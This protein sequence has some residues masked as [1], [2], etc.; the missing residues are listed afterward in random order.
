MPVAAAGAAIAAVLV[1]IFGAL[2]HG[3]LTRVPENTLK[4]GVGLLLATFGTFWAIEGLGI[5]SPHGESLEWPGS[6]F[7]LI[8]LLAGWYLLSRVLVKALRRPTSAPATPSQPTHGTA[9]LPAY[10][11]TEEA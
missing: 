4:Y 9:S 6:D 11:A 7:A 1:V 2:A 3:P 5:L 10:T 8:A